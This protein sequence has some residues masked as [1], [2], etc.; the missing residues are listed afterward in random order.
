MCGVRCWGPWSEQAWL[1]R[2]PRVLCGEWSLGGCG[3]RF[4]PPGGET[5][6]F[7]LAETMPCPFWSPGRYGDMLLSPLRSGRAGHVSLVASSPGFPGPIG[8]PGV[9]LKDPGGEA[10]EMAGGLGG[11][12][13]LPPQNENPAA[14]GYLVRASGLCP[15]VVLTLLLGW[16]S[17]EGDHEVGPPPALARDASLADEAVGTCWSFLISNFVL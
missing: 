1:G 11:F 4:L 3:Y 6:A 8:N 5:P 13:L 9:L 2:V 10:G 15:S 7:S 12:Q 16:S 17:G 14:Q